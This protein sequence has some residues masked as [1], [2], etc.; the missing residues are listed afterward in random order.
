MDNSNKAAP[1]SA[2]NIREA[3]KEQDERKSGKYQMM[4]AVSRKEL[5]RLVDDKFRAAHGDKCSCLICQCALDR[6]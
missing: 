5:I 1:M 3:I 2:E 6:M 4:F